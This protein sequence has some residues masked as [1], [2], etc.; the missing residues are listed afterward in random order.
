M[1]PEEARQTA[2]F[3]RAHPPFDSLAADAV[4]RVAACAELE[5]HASGEIVFAEGAEPVTHL[6]VIRSGVV[7]LATHGRVLDVLA[8]GDVFGHGSLLSGLAPAFTARAVED[9]TCYAIP[10]EEARAVLSGPA[11]VTF[12]ARSLLEEPTE[13][14]MLAREPA[15]NTADQPVGSL[16]RGDA[17]V[18][19]PDTPIREAAQMMSAGHSTSVVIDLRP[20]GLGILTD[21]DLRTKVVAAGMSVDAPVSAAMSA[22]AYTCTADRRAG[23]VLAEMFDR[24]LRHFPVL[25]P[26]GEIVG[27]V[28]DVDLVA[29]RT[30]SSFYL[31]QRIATAR[32]DVELVTISRELRPMIVSLFDAGV[33]ASNVMSVYAVCVDALTRRLLQFALERRGGVD[34]EFAWLALGSQARREVLPSSDV[35]SAIVWFDTPADAPGEGA[36]AARGDENEN[37][38]RSQLLEVAREVIGGLRACGLRIDENG[39]TADAA[40]FVRS[41]SSWQQVAQS[42]MS[43]PTQ[44]KAL[45]LTSVVVDNRPV[46]GVHTGTPVAD[47]FRL[48]AGS[49]RLLRMLARFALSH[50]PAARRFRGLTVEHGGEHPGTLDLKQG[51]LVPILDLARWGAMTAGVTS[52]TTPERLR[53]A[54]EAGTLAPADAHTLQDAFE[55]INNLRLEHQVAQIRAGRRPDDHVDPEQLSS[56]MRV[57][58]RQAFRAV[59]TIQKRVAAELDAGRHAAGVGS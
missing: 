13:L 33:A 25:S 59:A 53:A 57:Q 21:R 35:D 24:G 39:V 2:R 5:S 16:V 23:E 37:K 58:L 10:A 55:L 44:D 26:T 34:A 50:R 29:L 6:R 3:L 49:P 12:V 56:L 17:V 46:W 11:G 40:P 7:E 48:A 52:A 4:E 54:A 36:A 38:T 30:R 32:S 1:T 51:G 9:A 27:V 43:D 18:C 45:I 8:E 19:G 41:V 28:E 22:P 42:W 20:R 47:T 14:H 31:R 15:V